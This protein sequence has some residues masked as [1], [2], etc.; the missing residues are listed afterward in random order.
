MA[1]NAV[2]DWDVAPSN[3]IDI[4]GINIAEGCPAAGI[5]DAI[6]TVMA[7]VATWLVA[8][9][10]PLLKSGGAMTGAITGMG[11]GSTI[12]DGQISP[13]NRSV[14]YRAF[15]FT[16]STTGRTIALTDVGMCIPATGTINIPTNALV[17]FTVGDAVGVYNNSAGNI[18]ITASAGVTLRLGGSSTTGNRTLAQRGLATLIKVASDEWVALNG[19]VS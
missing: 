1:K 2:T 8:A 5:N 19:G 3:N 13:T 7:Q 11:N 10:G 6:R 4:A 12:S 15:P 16:G 17:A 9:A 18:S 14:G